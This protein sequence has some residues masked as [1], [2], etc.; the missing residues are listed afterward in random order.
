MDT[1][2]RGILDPDPSK[3]TDLDTQQWYKLELKIFCAI[4]NNV[5]FMKHIYVY[6]MFIDISTIK[7]PLPEGRSWHIDKAG[8]ILARSTECRDIHLYLT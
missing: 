1:D 6:V 2:F 4:V 3:A 8:N 7:Y 5:Q